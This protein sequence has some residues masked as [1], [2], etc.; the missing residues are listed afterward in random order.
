M[1]ANPTSIPL[2]HPCAKRG[3]HCHRWRET[4]MKY[5]CQ[6]CV[7]GRLRGQGSVSTDVYMDFPS[8]HYHRLWLCRNAIGF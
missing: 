2:R 6:E 3:S 5:M 8:S 7:R 1:M 4:P